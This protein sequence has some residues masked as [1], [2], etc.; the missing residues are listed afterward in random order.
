MSFHG[1]FELLINCGCN[2]PVHPA[3]IK[4]WWVWCWRSFSKTVSHRWASNKVTAMIWSKL[5]PFPSLTDIGYENHFQHSQLS[6]P[7]FTV[8][9][10][11]ILGKCD[12]GVASIRLSLLDDLG[13]GTVLQA[14]TVECAVFHLWWILWVML[15]A[16]KTYF[17]VLWRQE[18]DS[19]RKLHQTV[20]LGSSRYLR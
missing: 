14:K 7:G 5:K 2:Y 10:V 6:T 13:G 11:P 4:T 9:Y 20:W 16:S 1:R 12:F 17:S 8:S 18:L 19:S 3:G 15:H